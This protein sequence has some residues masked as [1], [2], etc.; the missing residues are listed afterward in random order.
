MCRRHDYASRQTYSL[1]ALR[2]NRSSQSVNL[3]ARRPAGGPWR[4]Q[5]RGRAGRR[6]RRDAAPDGRQRDRR[7]AHPGA[8]GAPQPAQPA[9][10]RDRRCACCARV[11]LYQLTL[12][13]PCSCGSPNRTRGSVTAPLLTDVSIWCWRTLSL[14]CDMYLLLLR[15][16]STFV[17]GRL[18]CLT[19]LILSRFLTLQHPGNARHELVNPLRMPGMKY[20]TP[21]YPGIARDEPGRRGACGRRNGRGRRRG[22][23]PGR[24]Q[25]PCRPRVG[26]E[27]PV[28]RF[29]SRLWR[30]S[31]AG[32]L[33]PSLRGATNALRNTGRRCRLLLLKALSGRRALVHASLLGVVRRKGLAACR[34]LAHI[35]NMFPC[36]HSVRRCAGIA[37]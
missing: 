35:K 4:R 5:G 23:R 21:K 10:A 33:L 2:R 24:H 34:R 7:H 19:Y 6:G 14:S 27:R 36:S 20:V 8:R 17:D 9:A 37:A 25:G 16:R 3:L 32:A 31:L 22:Q 29:E 30:S 18:A 15:K 26:Q 12:H 28:R 13:S 1:S 11:A